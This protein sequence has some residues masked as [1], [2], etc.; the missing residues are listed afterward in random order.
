MDQ[1]DNLISNF[2]E[3]EEKLSY[4]FNK[5]QLLI[6]AF[7][8][9][10]FYNENKNSVKEHNERLEFLGDAALN[11]IVSDFLYDHLPGTREGELSYLRAQIIN[12]KACAHFLKQLGVESFILLGKGEL[13]AHNSARESIFSDLF[14]AILGAIYLDGGIAAVHKFFLKHFSSNMMLTVESPSKNWKALLQDYAQKNFHQIPDYRLIDE[15]GP[16]H[17]KVFFVEVVINEKV[18][19]KGEGLSKKKAEQMAARDALEK[20][21]GKQN[22]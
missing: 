22:E 2:L 9:R 7:T 4:G 5:R 1:L 14:E 6:S 19:G 13:L 15:V 17:E 11:L 12:A 18:L 16:D 20:T 10:S 8:H 3:I 21:F